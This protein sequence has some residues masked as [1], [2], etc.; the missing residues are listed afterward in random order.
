MTLKLGSRR[1]LRKLEEHLLPGERVEHTCSGRYGGNM[2]L[3]VLTDLRLMLVFHGILKKR[4]EDFPIK[5]ISSVN[6]KS[7][8]VMSGLQVHVS[9]S[10]ALIDQLAKNDAKALSDR[11]RQRVMQQGQSPPPRPMAP[12]SAP[13]LTP[14]VVGDA[15]EQVERA[16]RLRDSGVLSEEEF[17]AQKRRLLS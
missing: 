7:G 17:Q 15:L 5:S 14:A 9:G 12:P 16:A 3:V 10:V 2:G 13:P 6:V 4:T 8:M 11:L 1:E